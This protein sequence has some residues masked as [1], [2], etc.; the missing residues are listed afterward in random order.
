MAR[1]TK[2]LLYSPGDRC[3]IERVE[4]SIRTELRWLSNT[5]WNLVERRGRDKR[6][7][8][9]WF[10][11]DRSKLS[12]GA[13]DDFPTFATF[14]AARETTIALLDQLSMCSHGIQGPSPYLLFPPAHESSLSDAERKRSGEWGLTYTD[15][16]PALSVMFLYS[17]PR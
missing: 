7:F 1:R 10:L 4:D 13:L 5:G 15:C 8:C 14:A 6:Q 16:M 2:E 11:L 12:V 9:G 3:Q 17:A